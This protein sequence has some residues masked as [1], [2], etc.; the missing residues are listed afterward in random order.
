MLIVV[1]PAWL[2]GTW[3]QT[4]K[5]NSIS[6]SVL[7]AEITK[8]RVAQLFNKPTTYKW[9][10][11]ASE[12]LLSFKAKSVIPCIVIR[13]KFPIQP[14]HLSSTASTISLILLIVGRTGG[15]TP[16]SKMGFGTK[17]EMFD[18]RN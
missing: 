9:K 2:K 8:P 4:A 16:G 15:F 7:A 14:T 6:L 3:L 17:K 11:L 10:T 1:F 5:L 12:Q 13:T 18:T